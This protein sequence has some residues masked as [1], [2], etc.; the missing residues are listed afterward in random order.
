MM[1]GRQAAIVDWLRIQRLLSV[2]EVED[3]GA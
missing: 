2:V 3:E 1:L